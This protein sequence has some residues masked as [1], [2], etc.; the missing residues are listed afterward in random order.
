MVPVVKNLL[1]NAGDSGS[2]PHLETRIPHAR[3]QL[4]KS[5]PSIAHALQ[6]EKPSN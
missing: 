2:I 6:Q 3:G 1:A 5:L 4:L